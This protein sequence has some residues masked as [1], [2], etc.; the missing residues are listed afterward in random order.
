MSEF[1]TEKINGKPITNWVA[2]YKEAAGHQ[3]SKITVESYSEEKELTDR[4]RKWW[5]GILLPALS[6]DTGESV[7]KWETRLKLAVLP[8]EF[9]PEIIEIEGIKCAYVPSI[10]KLSCKKTN[11]LI[12]GSV[13][14]LHDWGF[15]WV[16]LPDS[17]LRS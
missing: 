2:I 7:S 8:D 5:K 3:R 16:S 10:T 13:E 6:K 15:H 11:Q 14:K 12:E 1:I 9:Q 4:Q 17:S